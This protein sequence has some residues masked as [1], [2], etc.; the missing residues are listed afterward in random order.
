MFCIFQA[1]YCFVFNIWQHKLENRAYI[2]WFFPFLIDPSVFSNVCFTHRGITDDRTSFNLSHNCVGISPCIFFLAIGDQNTKPLNSYE[3]A[4]TLAY[5]T[6]WTHVVYRASTILDNSY[7]CLYWTSDKKWVNWG[8]KNA[9]MNISVTPS[10]EVYSF[11]T[12]NKLWTDDLNDIHGWES[13][14]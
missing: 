4:L 11:E 5:T 10:I 8:K 2:F 14:T 7:N 13:T 9:L 1:N 12:K 6:D 3:Y